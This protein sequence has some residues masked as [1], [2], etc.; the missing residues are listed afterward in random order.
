MHWSLLTMAQLMIS[1]AASCVVILLFRVV[2][3]HGI[4]VKPGQLQLTVAL[5]C[6]FVFGFIT[7]NMALKLMNVSLAM[8]LRATGNRHRHRRTSLLQNTVLVLRA[9]MAVTLAAYLNRP[10]AS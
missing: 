9:V 7:L 3:Y 4:S 8:T 5:S 6:S 2:P 10:A 1:T